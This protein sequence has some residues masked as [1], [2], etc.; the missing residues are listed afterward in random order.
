MLG[1]DIAIDLGTSTVKIYLDGKGIIL[2]EPSVAAVNLETGEVVATG[3]EAYKMVGRTSDR[4]DVRFPLGGGVISDFDLAR[5]LIS[6]YLKKI[7]AGRVI[8]PR[9]VVS[10]PCKITEVEKRA[11]VDAISSAGVRKICLIEEPVAAALGAGVDISAP[12][13]TL[14]VDVGGGTTDMAVLSLS[15][16]A[17]SRSLKVA[18]NAFDEAIIKYIRRKY[19][20]IIG[21]R[22]A[23]E[24]KIAVGCVY[25][26]K[27]VSTFRVK[28]R[29]AMTG[30]PQYADITSDEVLEALIESVMQIIRV[31]QEMLE[32]TPPELIGDVYTDGMILTG[33]SA[34]LY[35]F[36]SLISKK[37]K[38][39][40]L[41]AQEPQDCVAAGAGKA[42]RFID[43]MESKTYGILNPLSAAY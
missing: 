37:A 10:V 4:I 15:G 42:I 12:H 29:N 34:Y 39:P 14:V 40:V 33:G 17:I 35:G 36:D 19:N 3:Q 2:N 27:E 21:K 28:G 9:V 41:V 8:M 24:A 30:L 18:G 25:P 31:I 23:E 26:R 16:I 20:L 13:G 11:V 1:T 38:L 5:Y 7:N 43:D 22:M 6:S 32:K